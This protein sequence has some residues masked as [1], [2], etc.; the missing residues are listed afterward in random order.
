MRIDGDLVCS[1]WQGRSSPSPFGTGAVEEVDT[2]SGLAYGVFADDESLSAF[3]AN[4]LDPACR[5]PSALAGR[6]Q[7]RRVAADVAEFLAV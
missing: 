7:G 4:P 2:F 3:G 5:V 6:E 1:S